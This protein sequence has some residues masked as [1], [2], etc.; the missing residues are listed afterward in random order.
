MV[1]SLS[2]ARTHVSASVFSFASGLQCCCCSSTHHIRDEEQ[3][4]PALSVLSHRERRSIPRERQLRLHDQSLRPACRPWL[5]A[6]LEK[7]E[8]GLIPSLHPVTPPAS[9][10]DS[11]AGNRLQV[12]P[13]SLS[14]LGTPALLCSD[15]TATGLPAFPL[16][17]RRPQ[18]HHDPPLED[19]C[20]QRPLNINKE[21]P[22]A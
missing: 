17:F 19:G 5:R 13:A 18:D 6:R 15:P 11:S 9:G 20:C 4:T 22:R 16:L 3:D 10:D 14:S 12:A 21:W 7:P 2:D 1:P 8:S